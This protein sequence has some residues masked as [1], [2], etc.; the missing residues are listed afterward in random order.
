MD[1]V[2]SNAASNKRSGAPVT[3]SLICVL[4]LRKFR[5]LVLNQKNFSLHT[6][7]LLVAVAVAVVVAVVVAVAVSYSA[8]I[9]MIT[10]PL[11][12]SFVFVM[13]MR[14]KL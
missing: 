3:Q 14:S 2:R 5:H 11:A 12:H 8:Q 13:Q 6:L 7:M 9:K 10:P 4:Q 1:V